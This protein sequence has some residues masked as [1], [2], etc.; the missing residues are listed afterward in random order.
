MFLYPKSQIKTTPAITHKVAQKIAELKFNAEPLDFNTILIINKNKPVWVVKVK[1][2]YP[3]YV[4]IDALNGN[5]LY[6]GSLRAELPEDYDYGREVEVVESD[7][8]KEV[9]K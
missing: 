7:F 9:Y 4:G 5:V 2:I 1:S 3:I 8:I 6:S